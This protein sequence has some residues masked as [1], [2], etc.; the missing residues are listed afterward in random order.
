[1]LRLTVLPMAICLFCCSQLSAQVSI[2]LFNV[3]LA[4]AGTSADVVGK[5]HF[6]GTG[7]TTETFST[8]SFFEGFDTPALFDVN[9]PDFFD[10]GFLATFSPG[11]A[12]Q[13]NGVNLQSIE[14]LTQDFGNGFATTNTVEFVFDAVVPVGSSISDLNGHFAFEGG[15]NNLQV[16][17]IALPNDGT[18]VFEDT[19]GVVSGLGPVTLNV[20]SV[21]EPSASIGL[22]FLLGLRLA[23]RRKT[24]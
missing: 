7:L 16:A 14:L 19:N 1:M 18:F 24:L 8:V 12:P 2:D 13:L 21:P 9:L 10:E 11:S 3:Q 23:R 4:P 20:V 15:D 22:I 6:D 5:F 17:E